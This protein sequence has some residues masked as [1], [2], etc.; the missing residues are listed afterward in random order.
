MSCLDLF[1]A[2]AV[3]D[4][5]AAR[6]KLNCS[7]YWRYAFT[8]AGEISS[9]RCLNASK[10]AV[11]GEPD[12]RFGSLYRRPLPILN[13]GSVNQSA[14]AWREQGPGGKQVKKVLDKGIDGDYF[15]TDDASGKSKARSRPSQ[16]RKSKP[17]HPRLINYARMRV[18][19]FITLGNAYPLI[20][21]S[22]VSG[23][24]TLHGIG[25]ILKM[26]FQHWKIY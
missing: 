15:T 16:K 8:T 22:A 12:L 26:Q 24:T 1:A 6:K 23:F 18:I 4:T 2:A 10:D 13:G 9:E 14:S 20:D 7:I 11:V 3:N 19:V 17:W 21:N 25:I 5:V